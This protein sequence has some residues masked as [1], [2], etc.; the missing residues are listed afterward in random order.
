MKKGW[1]RVLLCGDLHCGHKVGLTPPAWQQQ[2]HSDGDAKFLSVHLKEK[3]YKVQSACWKW[4][5]SEITKLRPF[6]LAIVNGDAID[7]SGKRS[8][9]T[10]LITTD[11]SEQA[12][13]A[14]AALKVVKAPN[15]VFTFGTPYHTGTEEDYETRLAEWMDA[16]SWTDKVTMGAHEWPRVN[17]I[18]FDCKHKIG[19]S[20]NEA[21]QKRQLVTQDQKNREY[22]MQGLAPR[23]DILVRSH[24]H[25]HSRVYGEREE[26]IPRH[27]EGPREFMTL[28]ALQAMGTKYGA[29]QCVNVVHFGF[30]Y[31]DIPP[32]ESGERFQCHVKTL[33]TKIQAATVTDF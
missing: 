19:S 5:V 15:W 24:V 23:C 18:V 14:M 2:P 21:G 9:G 12:D 26:V 32:I 17:G 28:P 4:W 30:A 1:K 16:Q 31:V 3:F 25:Y 13:M 20:Q 7:G 22:W 33:P 11:R 8:G 6:H 29:R 27:Y 10:E